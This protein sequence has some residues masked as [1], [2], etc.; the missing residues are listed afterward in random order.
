MSSPLKGN[1]G[2]GGREYMN[3]L[4]SSSLQ[5]Y[6]DF[7][8]HIFAHNTENLPSYSSVTNS[9]DIFHSI[10]LMSGIDIEDFFI[11]DIGLNFDYMHSLVSECE[12][13][14]IKLILRMELMPSPQILSLLSDSKIVVRIFVLSMNLQNN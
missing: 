14:N 6:S 13:F 8:V 5:N 11:S 3:L 4:I 12:K 1:P 2:M 10:Q 7:K 9:R